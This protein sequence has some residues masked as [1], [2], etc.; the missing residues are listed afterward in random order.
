[1]VAAHFPALA[2]ARMVGSSQHVAH[3]LVRWIRSKKAPLE[4][5]DLPRKVRRIESNFRGAAFQSDA[6]SH[7]GNAL[8]T[9][10]KS[11]EHALSVCIVS[12]PKILFQRGSCDR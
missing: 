11:A 3:R 12:Q 5:F 6:L 8:V 7:G 9:R 4:A 10:C 1:M 2:I